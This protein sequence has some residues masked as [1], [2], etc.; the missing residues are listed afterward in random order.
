MRNLVILILV[1]I[2]C[3]SLGAQVTS[4]FNGK[5]NITSVTGTNPTFT[6]N[7]VFSNETSQYN[8]TQADTTDKLFVL[9]NSKAWKLHIKTYTTKTSSVLSFTAVDSTGLLPLVPTG[10]AAIIRETPNFDFPY[11]VSGLRN[12]LAAAI[13]NFY[14]NR[15]DEVL[16]NAGGDITG[17]FN[18][19]QIAPGAVG[20]TELADTSVTVD[21]LNDMGAL[22]N[23]YLKWDGVTWTPSYLPPEQFVDTLLFNN[24]TLYV[25]LS[26][27]GV[28]AASLYL[29]L[30]GA[31]GG[32]YS[33]GSGTVP[34]NTVA[35]IPDGITFST[36][37]DSVNYRV[38]LGNLF[39]S[40]LEVNADSV[41][42]Q[43][44]D[45]AGVNKL[46]VNSEGVVVKTDG[47]DRF[48][49]TGND[50]RYAADESASFDSLSLINKGWADSTYIIREYSYG[51]VLGQVLKWDGT[52]WYPA[53]DATGG[54]GA[55]ENNTGENV[56]A[57]Q[58]IYAGKTD[59]ILQFKTLV[60]GYG[61]D[62]ASDA[63]TVTIS[64]DTT[65]IATLDTVNSVAADLAVHV[66]LDQDFSPL[67]ELQSV[68]QFNISGDTLYLS[69]E[70][71][72]DAPKFVVLSD[73]L[74]NTDTSGYN[75][76]FAI[77][78]DTIYL[79]DGD[80]T[81]F[82][83]I[84]EA[85]YEDNQTLSLSNDTLYISQGNN[86]LL[87]GYKDNTDSQQLAIDSV[88]VG[89]LERFSISIDSGNTVRFDIPQ[90]TDTSGYNISFTRSNDTLFI[91][92]GNS[93]LFVKLPESVATDTSGY[94][95]QFNI[96]NDTLYITD[97]DGSLFV[98]LA[99]YLDNTDS[100]GYNQTFVR[101]NDTLYITDG[102]GQLFVTLP[103][104][105]IGLDTSGYNLDLIITN[106]TLY[107]TD[108]DGTLGVNLD[109]YLDNT[110]NQTLTVDST[111][112]GGTIERFGITISNG[113]T[114]YFDVPQVSGS[115]AGQ[116][117]VGANLGAGTGV[118]AG[119]VDTILQFKSLVEGF[120][121]DLSNT[122][123]EVTITVDTNQIATVTDILNLYNSNGTI[124]AGVNR[125]ISIDSTTTVT[126]TY[127]GSLSALDIYSGSDGSGTG[128]SI[129]LT[130][131]NGE[132]QIS[133]DDSAISLYHAG[134]N[135]YEL[136]ITPSGIIA[137]ING[138]SGN[139]GQVLKSDGNYLIWND[140]LDTSGYNIALTVSNDTLFLEDG[141]G[142]LSVELPPSTDAQTLSIDSTTVGNIERFAVSISN[143]NTVRFDVQQDQTVVLNEGYG[144]N[145]SGTYPNFTIAAD[146]TELATIND[147]NI[148]Q[149]DIDAHE[150]ADGDLSATNEGSLTVGA[151]GAN[152]ST[153]I[154]NTSGSTP[155]TIS[156]G[157]GTTVTESGS[158]ITVAADTTLLA[159]VNDIVVDD[160][161]TLADSAALKA[162]T[163]NATAIVLKQFG[164]E[165]TFVRSSTTL[166]HDGYI[167][168][169]DGS[170]RK[171][172]RVFNG[173]LN[174]KWFGARG[175]GVTDDI[176][177]IQR[178]I[179]YSIYTD[180]TIKQVY[181]PTGRYLISS[182]LHLGYGQAFHSVSLIGDGAP[183]FR[184]GVS[185]FNG[186]TIRCNFSNAPGIN[187]QG[188]RWTTVENIS[189]V[190]LNAIAGFLYDTSSANINNWIHASVDTI[191]D[192]RRTPYAG[193][194]VDAYSGSA[195]TPAYPTVNYPTYANVPFQYGRIQSSQVKIVNCGVHEFIAGIVLQPNSDGNGDFVQIEKCI[196][197]KV[198][199]GVSVGNTNSRNL[200]IRDC[201]IDA[202]TC[203]TNSTHGNRVGRITLVENCH[204][205]GYQWFSL[206]ALP[207]L[208]G[209]EI[210]N[211]YGE[212]FYWL[213]YIGD[214]AG[215]TPS[216]KFNS[217]DF[218]QTA[219]GNRNLSAFAKLSGDAAYVF[220]NCTFKGNRMYLFNNDDGAW[221]TFNQCKFSADVF[222]GE[223]G[224][225]VETYHNKF[226]R[227][228]LF[229][230]SA[231]PDRTT[232]NQCRFNEFTETNPLAFPSTDG[233]GTGFPNRIEYVSYWRQRANSGV[234]VE[235]ADLGYPNGYLGIGSGFDTYGFNGR[236]FTGKCKST[237][238]HGL[239][240]GDL[241]LFKKGDMVL[242][243]M[244]TEID[245]QDTITGLLMTNY[246][247]DATGNFVGYFV[248]TSLTS[249]S[250]WHISCR[251]F[252]NNYT[253]VGDFTAGSN[254][255]TNVLYTLDNANGATSLEQYT[256][257]LNMD[258]Y[259]NQR[260][261][262]YA[263]NVWIDSIISPTSFRLSAN[264]LRNGT[265]PI[266]N[267][268]IGD[269]QDRTILANQHVA[270][271]TG[272][273]IKGEADFK[274]D[275]SSNRL[276][277]SGA[278]LSRTINMRLKAGDDGN[279]TGILFETDGTVGQDPVQRIE[280]EST[281]P[282]P[283]VQRGQIYF[284][285]S[286]SGG[287]SPKGQA[288]IFALRTDGQSSSG[289]TALYENQIIF[290]CNQTNGFNIANN[291]G[292][293][294][295]NS[296]GGI[297]ST[298][299]NWLMSAG[300]YPN[301]DADTRLKLVGASSDSTN[302]KWPLRVFDGYNRLLFSVRND[303][304]TI[305][306]GGKTTSSKLLFMEPSG[307]G[308]NFTSI[309]AN[310]QA[311]NFE[312]VWPTDTAT[313]GQVLAWN[314]GGQ[315]S[316]ENKDAVT[317]L[318]TASGTL[319][320]DGIA[321]LAAASGFTFDYTGGADAIGLS[322]TGV[323]VSS[324][325]AGTSLTVIDGVLS[326]TSDITSSLGVTSGNTVTF[327][328][329]ETQFAGPVAIS[330][331]GG[332]VAIDDNALLQLDGV[333]RVLLLNRLTTTERNALA[334]P[335]D[336]ALL[337]NTTTDALTVRANGAW[338]E[339]GSGGGDGNGIYDGSGTIPNGTVATLTSLGNFIIDYNS[340][341]PALSITDNSGVELYSPD[342]S[343]FLIAFNSVLQIGAGTGR[344]LTIN[345]TDIT[346][347]HDYVAIDGRT[348]ANPGILRFL[349]PNGTNYFSIQA[350]AMTA[351]YVYVWPVDDGTS[352]QVLQTDG[353]GN[354]SWT[355]V[356]GAD[357][358][359]IYSGD[360]TLS[361]GTTNALL[362]ASGI[363][364]LE[365]NGTNA[366]LIVD[367]LNS[368]TTI[369]SKDG[370]QYFSADNTQS[371]IGSGASKMEYIDGV[372]RLYDSD[373]TQYVA[374]QTPATGSLTSNYTLTLPID[375]GTPDQLLKT[376]GSGNLSWTTVAGGGD[377][378]NGGNTT[379]AAV[380]IG[381]ND[382]NALNLE[383]N[384]VE[385]LSITG[386]AS[387]G[388][389]FTFTNVTANTNTIQDVLTVRSNST[390][391]VAN[392]FGVGLLFQ[393]ESSTTD[394]RDMIKLSA[395]WTTATDGSRASALVYNDVTGG[396]ALTERF[397]FTPTGMIT[398]TAYTIGGSGNSITL[399]GSGGLI[400]LSTAN[401][402]GIAI[403]TTHNTASSTSNITFGN[404]TSFTQI[405]GTRNYINC[406]W[407]FA[408]TSGTAVH[409]QLSFT[410]TF[411]QT[412]GANGITRGIFLN[413]ALTAVADFRG[414]E[415]AYSNSN[416]KGV[417]QTGS[418]TT[419]NLVGNTAFGTTNA[420]NAT[421][422]IDM[423]STTK[424]FGLPS[425]T[426]TQ[427]DAIST[428][429]A[430]LEVYNS[431]DNRSSLYN[432]T[433]WNNV[434]VDNG[435]FLY[436]AAPGT[437]LTAS[438]QTIR[439]TANENQD[440]G[441]VCFINVDGEAQLGDAD[442]LSTSKVTVLCLESA[443]ANNPATYLVQGIARNDT[444][445]WTVGGVVYLSTTGT[446]GN[447]L[448][449]TA[450]SGTGDIVQIVGIATHADRILFNPQLTF[451]EIQ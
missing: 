401:T 114:V 23:Q 281:E 405:S 299:Q 307:S 60:E 33:P 261:A 10:Q 332:S 236:T 134:T 28:P 356:G 208:E 429:R 73:Y 336:G 375:D 244:V 31:G 270:Y 443:T 154:S 97:G 30:G 80:G 322:G 368:A 338:V 352:N 124:P 380:T 226:F 43:H 78:N 432:G 105:Q 37:V 402:T 416:A 19:L 292:R 16:S 242:P 449:Q 187:I 6:I 212:A 9:Y 444:W 127:A 1:L 325:D 408:P 121:I 420:P 27:D 172:K 161:V 430:G 367:D 221:L 400:T 436:A 392:N 386:G 176:Y 44:S 312:Y 269:H 361:A 141:N 411:N 7:G 300:P 35:D 146:T 391:T 76:N 115:G 132:N 202:H 262:P 120:G 193:I 84:P 249:S 96:S 83:K 406:N 271:G 39:W 450:P 260:L 248:D 178:A 451:I 113:N 174:V 111:D 280:W 413:Q 104:D 276:G 169:T 415:I 46:Y 170:N 407:G 363:F 185:E 427:R 341:S 209:F 279:N 240:P 223:P 20:T 422:L 2:G 320:A 122:S 89:G 50:A 303:G 366:G 217:C 92:D 448:T 151:G 393:G 129:L 199:Y 237:Y 171:W 75:L 412:G 234:N 109:P 45:L 298:D 40:L 335:E 21:K 283:F 329:S 205:G 32:I 126:F 224:D 340:S 385:R 155:V 255:V 148:V 272:N 119:K 173:P 433:A 218:S 337:Y 381:T 238:K 79:T 190:G 101:S 158:T 102:D 198:A 302:T 229:L 285:A 180:T 310:A 289:T 90:N 163:G 442:A 183:S 343:G 140:D 230:M 166:P 72:G 409:N 334:S 103:P 13:S 55:G 189:V 331:I 256:P 275:D 404:A 439:L 346:V 296:S 220:D 397:R 175:D 152:T 382:A 247:Y 188:A 350:Q 167:V 36:V 241:L 441:D 399:G 379:G 98:D 258:G 305:I 117:N 160:V 378:L 56:G 377:I 394:N 373:A 273:G 353:S 357:G 191:G 65:Q 358:N 85:A 398:N 437:N 204:F 330:P 438:G 291:T 278:D 364:R 123:T 162:Y 365:Y 53:N 5:F 24:D 11:G 372:M 177:A 395:I 376:D 440:F 314:T 184:G 51:G 164:R 182:T 323:I 317:S 421:A 318:Y 222:D 25:S 231:Y 431:T 369:F 306:G 301:A 445:A 424:G 384:N 108:G 203:I 362:P 81:L 219:T 136:T 42:I 49:I 52:K 347:Q 239:G 26:S 87:T 349:E 294:R 15:V 319:F 159:T 447:T 348:A 251:K 74:D 195:P 95:S 345:N 263:S 308:T 48:I 254:I 64:V 165:G 149:A 216:I 390:G 327:T 88:I 41:R 403:S 264:A 143:G 82:V 157:V 94:N 235:F 147:I 233:N 321:T 181:I 156:G 410:G 311:T 253:V 243:V 228:F 389:A 388:G 355:T 58:G 387:T 286:S 29:P 419:N 194:T 70:D 232:V 8:G 359:G 227:S 309:R 133:L 267:C 288:M 315:L 274:Y 418:L 131:P 426:S 328:S 265:Y 142:T 370:T 139:A 304:E 62:Y 93:A 210:T 100:S 14:S 252:L 77:S 290:N 324:P 197:D 106:D 18:N 316:W 245:A 259:Y 282:G 257:L 186:T 145:N 125:I 326:G 214:F 54:S 135:A 200:A 192:N 201:Y 423:V 68:D 63:T 371:I 333:G 396:G 168:F 206:G 266:Q 4:S 339:L 428:P 434:V 414:I 17:P 342:G 446:T 67:N 112:I 179:D 383:T 144:I 22:A 246:K 360:G 47:P 284:D 425:M 116:N 435:T 313:A 351:D 297:W 287:A 277:F 344:Q 354:L 91:V 295:F 268:W 59:T 107:V 196:I 61:I 34:A 225:S 66:I 213:G 417:Y 110:D 38:A 57:G 150:L 211:C 138:D 153:I 207:Y 128:G 99:P 118:Y 69:L 12:D 3:T 215:G 250:V 71:D 86:V 374:I 130:S 137:N 293:L